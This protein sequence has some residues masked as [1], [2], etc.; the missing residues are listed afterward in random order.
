MGITPGE[1]AQMVLAR[2]RREGREEAAARLAAALGKVDPDLL[3][4]DE[5]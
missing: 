5:G 4:P 1:T 2:L 3:L